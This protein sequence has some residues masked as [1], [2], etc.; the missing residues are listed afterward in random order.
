M[1]DAVSDIFAGSLSDHWRS[2]LGRR[3]PFMY[4]SCV[5]L[6]ACFFLLFFP[7]VT[8][9]L[10]LLP[11]EDSISDAPAGTNTQVVVNSGGGGAVGF[12]LLLALLAVRMTLRPQ[13]ASASK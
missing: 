1:V 10:A 12:F 5:P 2:K 8:S 13:A 6:A 7:L 4:A 3:H 11:L 9:E